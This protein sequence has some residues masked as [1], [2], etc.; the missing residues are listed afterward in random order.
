MIWEPRFGEA[1]RVRTEAHR[2]EL[3]ERL[4]ERRAHYVA[5][6]SH[7]LFVWP[8]L[9]AVR[10]RGAVDPAARTGRARPDRRARLA[11]RPAQRGR[12]RARPADETVVSFVG[13]GGLATPDDIEAYE[14]VQRGIEAT[15]GAARPELDYSD[16]SRGMVDE[17]KG[18]QGRSIDEGAMRGF[19]RHWIEAVGHGDALAGHRRPP[20]EVP[21]GA[22]RAVTAVRLARS[23]PRRHPPEVEDFLYAEADLLDAWRYDDWLALFEEG[24]RYE[25]PTTDYQRLVAARVRLVRRRRLGSA[26]G[27]GEAAEVAQGPRR[28]PALA[29]ATAGVER[30]RV[31]GRR[32]DGTGERVV[33]GLPRPRR[34]LRHL[35]RPLRP[36]PRRDRRG[37]RF[38]LRRSILGHE[39]LA[40]GARL[41]FIL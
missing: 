3:V 25:I 38:R 16:M 5:D 27:A 10:H 37:L 39:Q 36:R 18:V 26:A 32:R 31:P 34:A 29:H 20:R 22:G 2:A 13:P 14:A 7:I 33:R 9:L 40:P 35:R 15:A 41:S 4:G 28:E 12:R 21:R 11:T 30:A 6:E 19:W 23:A 17:V 24:A 8:N 1:E